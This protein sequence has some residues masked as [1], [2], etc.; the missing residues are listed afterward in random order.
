V[1]AGFVPPTA[2]CRHSPNDSSCSSHRDYQAPYEPPARKQKPVVTPDADDYDVE[3]VERIGPHV[4]MKVRYPNCKACSYEGNKV[5]VFLNVSEKDI[6]RW[7]KIDPHF[8]EPKA[9]IYPKEAPA[10]AARFPAS[11]DGWQDAIAYARC[12]K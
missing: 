11:P 3:E 4:V 1:I 2:I 9:G 12:K 10:P 5:M 8:R 6:L 7:R